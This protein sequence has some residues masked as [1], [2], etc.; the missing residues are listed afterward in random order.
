MGEPPF[1]NLTLGDL[2]EI[3]EPDTG[4]RR[5]RMRLRLDTHARQN[6]DCVGFLCEHRHLINGTV[7]HSVLDRTD[8]RSVRNCHRAWPI[9]PE[10][11]KASR[12]AW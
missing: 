2:I 11:T 9:Q 7:T 6:P 10:P 3:T 4:L 5:Q 1:R 12:L 8:T